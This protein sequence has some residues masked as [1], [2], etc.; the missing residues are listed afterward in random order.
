MGGTMIKVGDRLPEGFFRVKDKDGNARKVTTD[1]LFAGQKVALVGV[2]AAFS[3]TCH[4]AHIPRF[5]ADADRIKAKGVDRIAVMAVND[6]HVMK[7]WDEALG[8]AGKLDFLSDGSATYTRALGMDVDRTEAGMGIR[9]RRFS[10]IVEDGVVKAI[11]L[12]PEGASGVTVTGAEA[13]IEQ[14]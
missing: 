9:S 12:E 8:G 5:V 1:D 11:N 4:N 14:L 13:M 2:P 6:H 3:S 7:V 10:M